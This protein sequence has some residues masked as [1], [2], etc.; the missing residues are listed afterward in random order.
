MWQLANPLTSWGLENLTTLTAGQPFAG[1]PS[2][3][4]PDAPGVR[5]IRGR[6]SAAL[7]VG[8]LVVAHQDLTVDYA[9]PLIAGD[10]VSLFGTAGPPQ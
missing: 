9:G 1:R 6:T 10:P 5:A 7:L 4:W 2:V 3:P 8:R